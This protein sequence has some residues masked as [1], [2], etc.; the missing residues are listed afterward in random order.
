MW[1]VYLRFDDQGIVKTNHVRTPDSPSMNEILVCAEQHG[2]TSTAKLVE[3]AGFISSGTIKLKPVLAP[4]F[5]FYLYDD[6]LLR[7]K[8]VTM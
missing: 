2:L 5:H 7:W 4:N 8:A 6:W 3:Y 1:L